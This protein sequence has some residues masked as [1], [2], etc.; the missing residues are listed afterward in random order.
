MAVN[1]DSFIKKLDESRGLDPVEDEVEDTPEES[2]EETVETTEDSAEET[3]TEG[4]DSEES[5]ATEEEELPDN[6]KEI[7][8][9]NRKAVREAEARANAAEKALAEKDNTG[10]ETPASE[11]DDR[12]K[13]L[14]LNNSAKNALK[15]AGF[16][17]GTERFLKMLDLDSVEVD[18]D[19]NITGLEDQIDSIKDEFKDLIAPKATVKK[20]LPKTDAAGRKETPAPR[21]SSADL[22]ADRL[23]GKS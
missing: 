19:G 2:E 22:I 14:Y 23:T 8:K 13:K 21:K 5:E 16:A 15:D 1:R 7:L 11:S 18:E 17:N 9:K 12:F 6:I 3:E 20:A 10:E 4:E